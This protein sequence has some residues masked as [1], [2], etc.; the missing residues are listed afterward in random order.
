MRCGTCCRKGGPVLHHEDKKILREGHI[1]YQHL[2]TLRIGER[3]YNPVKEMPETIPTEL[4]K[5]ADK[6]FDRSCLFYDGV[7]RI[8]DI[9]TPDGIFADH[10]PYFNVVPAFQQAAFKEAAPV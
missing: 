6:G 5:I 1:G 8:D 3:A 2:I 10:R 4:V 9:R 7:I